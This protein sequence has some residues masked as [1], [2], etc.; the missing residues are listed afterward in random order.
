MPD[1]KHVRNTAGDLLGYRFGGSEE[2]HLVPIHEAADSV[3]AQRQH[4]WVETHP[5]ATTW[6]LQCGK[7]VPYTYPEGT[8]GL[9]EVNRR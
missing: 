4:N 5:Q 6:A 7:C 2:A 8:T 3:E 1:N 9:T